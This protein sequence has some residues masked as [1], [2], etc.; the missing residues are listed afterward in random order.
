MRF[1]GRCV[2][3]GTM[4]ANDNELL[5]QYVREQSEDAFTE[6][7]RRHVR[8]VYSAALRQMNGDRHAAEDVAQAVFSDLAR[9]APRL[10]GHTCLTGWLFTST[11]FQASKT[12]VAVERRIIREHAAHAMNEILR[13]DTPDYDWASIRPV[14]DDALEELSRSD[15]D[16]VLWRYFEQRPFSEIGGRLGLKENAARM[17]VERA[18]EKLRAGFAKRGVSS[19][20]VALAAALTA[21]GMVEVPPGLAERVARVSLAAGAAGGLAWLLASTK[22]MLTLST[23]GLLL[24]AGILLYWSSQR[25][26][27]HGL[28]PVNE[29][30]SAAESAT[31]QGQTTR[32]SRSLATTVSD[33][34]NQIRQFTFRLSVIA[35]QDSRPVQNGEISCELET[36]AKSDTRKLRTDANGVLGIQIPASTTKLRLVTQIDGFADTRLEWHQDRGEIIPRQY[37][38]R[39]APCVSLGG[40]VV[41]A[42][43]KPLAGAKVDIY[44]EE[45]TTSPRPE[46][47]VAGCATQT[48]EAGR[49]RIC[50]VAPEL[51]RNLVLSASHPS[52]AFGTWLRVGVEADAEQ[53]LRAE[54]YVFR[55]GAATGLGGFVVDP[56]GNPVGGAT[57]RVG[58]LYEVGDRTSR[59]GPDGG[60]SITGCQAGKV[61]LT[62][63][64]EGFAPTSI[65][66]V[67]GTNQE[68]VRLVLSRGKPLSVRVLDRAGNPVTNA[69]VAVEPN[70]E[71]HR[72]D[73][74]AIGHAFRQ[75]RG[76]DDQGQ[77]FFGSLPEYD[78]W[79][80][81]SARGFISEGGLK[82]RAGGPELVVTVVSNLVVS[83]T[84]RDALT[85]E[86]IPKF[87]IRTGKPEPQG[88]YFSDLDRFVPS[89]AGGE[90]RHTYD[91]AVT[92]GENAGYLLRFEADGYAPFVSRVVA[93]DEGFAQLDVTLQPT[94]NRRFSVLNPD[95]TPASWADV[96]LLDRGKGNAIAVAPGGLEHHQRSDGALV[97]TDSQGVLTAPAGELH[98]VA[99]ANQAG[100][101]A[102]NLDG[103]ADGGNLKLQSWGHVEGS[104]PVGE[105]NSNLVIWAD[106]VR[107]PEGALMLG[108]SFRVKPDQ[109]GNFILSRVPPGAIRL[110]VQ[111]DPALSQAEGLRRIPPIEVEVQ[112]G[113]ATN[114][115]FA[116]QQE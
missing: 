69:N 111:V 21:H 85:G 6:L 98:W 18:L 20:A 82:A 29:A 27:S 104:L 77:A 10:L 92:M 54:S 13:N 70:L 110:W 44:I 8:L 80:G 115:S 91:E 50:R 26:G 71:V 9:K 46:C 100:Y 78:L 65:P 45:P 59:T 109:N 3:M 108:S 52:L 67:A 33:D 12:R 23:A 17:R 56:E 4:T 79:V 105:T 19:S 7:V 116:Y 95:G 83:G 114:A 38:L 103:V 90:F 112:P 43:N 99:I 36:G 74:P 89:F 47:H 96:G 53:Q 11:R 97:Q 31:P 66:T 72:P 61:V 40:S 87:R 34:F 25:S 86:P 107:H 57:V 39:L 93:P 14:L 60:F 62:A 106:F 55:L 102:T 51:V 76:T 73:W 75:D 94:V 41:D 113:E 42:D 15:R 2:L 16:V 63:E 101:V 1:S 81:V 68:P 48:D 28:R 22:A 37:A 58:G 30:T 35:A 32:T 84:V 88:P 5:G 24:V 49:W 64:A